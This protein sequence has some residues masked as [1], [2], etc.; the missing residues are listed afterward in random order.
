M[1][2]LAAVLPYEPTQQEVSL[3]IVVAGLSGILVFA[4]LVL[5]VWD[6]L[7]PKPPL[8]ERLRDYATRTDLVALDQRVTAHESRFLA[9]L[10]DLKAERKSDVKA[11][12]DKI[13]DLRETVRKG[14]EDT[15]RDIGRIEGKVE[16][17]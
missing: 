5:N 8:D 17:L 12:Y 13:D 3:L 1:S 14:F 16:K 7:K 9:E 15:Q 10:R 11:L 4:N 6:R 2:L